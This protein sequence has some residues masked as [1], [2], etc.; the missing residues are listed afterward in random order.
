MSYNYLLFKQ[1]NKKYASLGLKLAAVQKVETMRSCGN[2]L[3]YFF[4]FPF[5]PPLCQFFRLCMDAQNLVALQALYFI[6]SLLI[7]VA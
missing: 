3:P 4:F 5:T 2:S 1:Q 7:V 6:S